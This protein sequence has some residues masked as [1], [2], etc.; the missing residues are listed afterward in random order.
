M[1]AFATHGSLSDRSTQEPGIFLSPSKLHGSGYL[2]I[3]DIAAVNLRADLVILSACSSAGAPG[4]AFRDRQ[5]PSVA[6][7]FMKAGAKQVLAAFSSVTVGAAQEVTVTAVKEF[8]SDPRHDMARAL[9]EAMKA[10]IR[11]G[12]PPDYWAPFA[13][14]GVN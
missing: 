7:S 5:V 3:T 14:F 4:M 10:Q 6:D 12:R 2:G 13:Y 11:Q 8:A 9:Q 1:F